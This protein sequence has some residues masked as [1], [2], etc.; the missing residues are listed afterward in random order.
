MALIV[1]GMA[2]LLLNLLGI[3]PVASW[4]WWML[5]APF[6]G[7]LLWWQ[8]SDMSGRTRRLQEDRFVQRRKARRQRAMDAMGLGQRATDERRV[9][10]SSR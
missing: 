2:L 1:I 3:E 5:V 6:G 10:R 4:P 9:K 7:A 8:W